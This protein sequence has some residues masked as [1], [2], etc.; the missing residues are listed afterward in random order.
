MK[1]EWSN[2]ELKNEAQ[3][4]HNQIVI[5]C[6][7]K[8]ARVVGYAED[9]CD[10]YLVVRSLWGK[11][12]WT[13]AVGWCI[14]LKGSISDHDYDRTESVFALNDCPPTE[15]MMFIKELSENV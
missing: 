3:E 7:D 10:C 8:L 1:I 14:P 4:L 9:F 12:R 11:T 5:A 15:K 6:D 2:E 13:T